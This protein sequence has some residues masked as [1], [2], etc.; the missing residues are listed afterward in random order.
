ME[1]ARRGESWIQ[2]F[3]T[4]K[5]NSP[6]DA[7]AEPPAKPVPTTMMSRRRLLAGVTNF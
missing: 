5:P 1:C 4:L 6:K 7:A 3:K 2:K